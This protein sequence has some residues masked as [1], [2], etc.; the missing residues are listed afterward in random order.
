MSVPSAAR[1][2]RTQQTRAPNPEE[3][4]L[5]TDA[6]SLGGAY[7]VSPDHHL[8]TSFSCSSS[9]V[10]PQDHLPLETAHQNV[11]VLGREEK[12]E[13]KTSYIT[14]AVITF[15]ALFMRFYKIEHPAQ[16]V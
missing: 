5:L 13:R 4:P 11:A 14:A 9:P 8:P 12:A 3:G 2:R 6:R 16:V 7:D 1:Q 10:Q 15:A